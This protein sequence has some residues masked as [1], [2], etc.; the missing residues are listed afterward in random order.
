MSVETIIERIDAVIS[1]AFNE[2]KQATREAFLALNAEYSRYAPT[3]A[4]PVKQAKEIKRDRDLNLTDTENERI[5]NAFTNLQATRSQR[6]AF[7]SIVSSYIFDP[8]EFNADTIESIGEELKNDEK[9]LNKASSDVKEIVNNNDL[10]PRP[11]IIDVNCQEAVIPFGETFVTE[12]TVTNPSDSQ[13]DAATAIINIGGEAA[14]SELDIAPIDSGE[15]VTVRREV[16]SPIAEEQLIEV[17]VDSP[18]L[19]VGRSGQ[20]RIDVRSKKSYASFAIDNIS[21]L[22]KTIEESES[23]PSEQKE[24]IILELEAAIEAVGEARKTAEEDPEDNNIKEQSRAQRINSL[25]E[26]A[27][28]TLAQAKREYAIATETNDV[29]AE[30]DATIRNYFT[31]SDR[32]LSEGQTA[33]L[34]ESGENGQPNNDTTTNTICESPPIQ[35]EG[36]RVQNNHIITN[37]Q[38][39]ILISIYITGIYGDDTVSVTDSFDSQL[40]V[41]KEDSDGEVVDGG[42]IRFENI[43]SNN[44]LT[45]VAKR[46]YRITPPEDM[47]AEELPA[48]FR[49]GPTELKFDDSSSNEHTIGSLDWVIVTAESQDG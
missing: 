7:T 8:A 44:G 26:T 22:K 5:K 4:S 10:S 32:N 45:S 12:F 33:G 1:T 40:R 3:I 41:I 16:A 6:F 35:A 47:D 46:Q 36:T 27:K 9:I 24:T 17:N 42:L 21:I 49:T 39:S 48:N 13:L 15:V 43:K 34:S 25:F 37:N 2:D 30:T 20:D 28:K 38:D 18:T 29:R 31:L 14:C 19:D 11:V 23:I